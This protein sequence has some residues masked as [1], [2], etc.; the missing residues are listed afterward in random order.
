MNTITMVIFC[1]QIMKFVSP[2][3]FYEITNVQCVYWSNTT[4]FFVDKENQLEVTFVY[5]ISLLLVAQHVSGNH[6]CI[7]HKEHP[8]AITD[9]FHA[10][11]HRLNQ[12]VP[13]REHINNNNLGH[14]F[15]IDSHHGSDLHAVKICIEILEK[16]IPLC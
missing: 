8:V 16:V 2:L 3:A 7:P 15:V 9:Q 12:N 1:L 14:H 5:F 10:Q 11:L 6:T 13:R 4:I